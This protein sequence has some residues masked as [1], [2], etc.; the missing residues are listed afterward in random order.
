MKLLPCCLHFPLNTI[1]C[2][3]YLYVY[4]LRQK[5][6][7]FRFNVPLFAVWQVATVQGDIN[8]HKIVPS[9]IDT[10]SLFAAPCVQKVVEYLL[11][12]LFGADKQEPNCKCSSKNSIWGQTGQMSKWHSL[13]IKSK[14]ILCN[15]PHEYIKLL[16]KKCMWWCLFFFSHFI[17]QLLGRKNIPV[18]KGIVCFL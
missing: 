1:Y 14:L 6:P 12:C 3:A 17:T 16:M 5:I 8:S 2:G 9:S 4:S 11:F 15:K 18:I 13:E 7:T 10:S